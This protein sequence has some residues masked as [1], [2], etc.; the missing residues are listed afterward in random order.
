MVLVLLALA[1]FLWKPQVYAEESLAERA[2]RE[3]NPDL[4]RQAR[5]VCYE[6]EFE[7]SCISSEDMQFMCYRDYAVAK[8]EV[9]ICDRL[10]AD[11][12][13]GLGRNAC[14]EQ[15]ARGKKNLEMC[16]RLV[17]PPNP[18]KGRYEACIYSV[19]ELRKAFSLEDCLKI[20]DSKRAYFIDCVAG[21][22]YYNRQ[23]SLCTEFFSNDLQV[24]G[25][26]DTPLE[27]CIKR[28]EFLGTLEGDPK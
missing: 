10:R 7:K 16:E 9:T 2:I 17:Q 25:L 3:S 13:R 22:A 18:D 21:L 15:Y 12:I 23:P 6:G 1:C 11:S 19:Q 24:D 28:V 5:E 4:C 20:R 14:I 26:G 27:R 8:S